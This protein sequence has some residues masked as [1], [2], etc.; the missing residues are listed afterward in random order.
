MRLTPTDLLLLDRVVRY[1]AVTVPVLQHTVYSGTNRAGTYRRLAR[2]VRVGLLEDLRT[3]ES[4]RGRP[5]DIFALYVA[6]APAYT[7]VHSDLKPRP[8]NLHEVRHTLAVA[9][10]GL[11]LE[12]F[13]HHVVSDRQIKR[14]LAVWKASRP[15][16]T[17]LNAH[18]LHDRHGKT[19]VPDLAIGPKN[20]RQ[21]TAVEVELTFK[22][23]KALRTI[24]SMYAQSTTYSRV[25]Y[26]VADG[27]AEQRLK[28]LAAD[29]RFGPDQLVVRRYVPRHST[30]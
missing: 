18:W 14:D 7:L 12:R 8:V 20:G 2:L 25:I 1:H 9:E 22:N 10:V 13:R 17:P 16:G 3:G 27:A 15:S 21:T 23:D 11:D 29:L 19:H 28:R 5:M 30:A 26:Y 4:N 6:T 24:L